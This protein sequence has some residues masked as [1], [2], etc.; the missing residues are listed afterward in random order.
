ME[1][2]LL[3]FHYLPIQKRSSNKSTTESKSVII[4][5]ENRAINGF[6][7]PKITVSP[8]FQVDVTQILH[9]MDNFGIKET[10]ANPSQ[11]PQIS[12]SSI[13]STTSK[14]SKPS[15]L[16][17]SIK[18]SSP[19]AENTWYNRLILCDSLHGMANLIQNGFPNRVQMI[20][21]DP[22][23]GIDFRGKI[24][25]DSGQM[26]GY[27]DNWTNGLAGYLAHLRDRFVLCRELLS[28][29]GSIFVQIGETNLHYVR[30]LLDE[31]F[32]PEN[33][34]SQITFR[35]AISTNKIT[36]VADYL[37]WYAKDHTQ[38]YRRPLFIE[39]SDEKNKSTFTYHE[40]SAN[41]DETQFKP[42][43]LVRRL[44]PTKM[45]V[46][47]FKFTFQGQDFLPPDGF[48]W[49]WTSQQLQELA[50]AGRITV[51]NK[52]L[53]GK[54]FLKDFPMMILTNIWTDTST[55]TFA[56]QKFYSV[57]TNPKV[58]RRCICMTT[59]PGD[60]VLDP[61][62]GSG[63]TPKT[64]E[65]LGRHWIAFDTYPISI[66]STIAWLMTSVYPSYEWNANHDDFIYKTI[67]R[68][69]L[70]AMAKGDIINSEALYDQPVTKKKEIHYC[71]PF[72]LEHI[73]EYPIIRLDDNTPFEQGYALRGI[74]FRNVIDQIPTYLESTGILLPNNDRWILS[75]VIYDSTNPRYNI[76]S[77]V[78]IFSGKFS[79]QKI[80]VL[81]TMAHFRSIE[82]ALTQLIIAI[83]QAEPEVHFLIL[84]PF[85]SNALHASTNVDLEEFISNGIVQFVYITPTFF[86]EGVN[87]N[88]VPIFQ[89]LGIAEINRNRPGLDLKFFDL[90]SK[91]WMILNQKIDDNSMIITEAKEKSDIISIFAVYFPFFSKF[92][93]KELDFFTNKNLSNNIHRLSYNLSLISHPI[94]ILDTAYNIYFLFDFA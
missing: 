77:N 55:S 34:I 69:S 84:T 79:N 53:Y 75:S 19:S 49:R 7:I 31:I 63:T 48:E 67:P 46:N 15:K 54:R 73:T 45:N 42:Q 16:P 6:Q 70:S 82:Q 17:V 27:N 47:R 24:D 3:K 80:Y 83:I 78:L 66:Y 62:C 14:S 25:S 59:K 90:T 72:T 41:S 11:S 64:A 93:Q 92:S 60:L 57:H 28:E 20:Y 51:I 58:I 61:T 21:F 29:S 87:H 32:G 85:V 35:T 18:K 2:N 86:C 30:V 44:T 94:W 33:F 5:W 52:K 1:E 68:A 13:S 65:E 91:S 50:N 37:L 56:A 71:T 36:N 76:P 43:E 89:L 26:E 39:R 9:D 38:V 40:D 23:F 4:T 22:P 88:Q 8:L 10:R 74:Y 12:Q 81:V